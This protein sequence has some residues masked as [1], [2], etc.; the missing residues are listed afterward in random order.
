MYKKLN[1]LY[2]SILCILNLAQSTAIYGL[3]QTGSLTVICGSMCS[4]KSEE[5]IW[6]LHRFQIAGFNM[7]TFKPNLDDRNLLNLEKDPRTYV[8]SRNGS[9]IQCVP[10]D[11][12]IDIL[13]YPNITTIKVIA[14]DEVMLFSDPVKE[15]V[16]TITT[17]LSMGKIIF[18]AGLDL[19]FRGEPFGSMPQLL[20]MAD[21]VIKLKAICSVCKQDRYCLT[22]RLMNGQ[23]AHYNDPV[24]VVD[25]DK[26]VRYEPRCRNCHI[27]LK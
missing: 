5:L 24:I 16:S 21:Q 17:L 18:L 23:P 14:I 20:T 1:F 15:L 3:D 19:D 10:L 7:I 25:N 6:H 11:N 4:G 8:S 26:E 27:I 2:F 22:Q 13:N 12:I 9:W